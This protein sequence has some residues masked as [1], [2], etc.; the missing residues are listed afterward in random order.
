MFSIFKS[1]FHITS[2][3][4]HAG[5]IRTRPPAMLS[6]SSYDEHRHHHHHHRRR[7]RRRRRLHLSTISNPSATIRLTVSNLNEPSTLLTRVLCVCMYSRSSRGGSFPSIKRP[8][9]AQRLTISPG[10]PGKRLAF[11]SGCADNT[12]SST[13]E[14]TASARC[15]TIA[16]CIAVWFKNRASNLPREC[17]VYRRRCTRYRSLPCHLVKKTHTLSKKTFT[18]AECR[19]LTDVR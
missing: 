16:H 9:T 11:R 15:D 18:R 6:R 12:P 19:W 17:I 4:M 10:C 5:A 14:P 7:L 2:H 8:R 1:L 13:S 3:K